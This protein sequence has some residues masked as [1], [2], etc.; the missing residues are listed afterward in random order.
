MA[1][2]GL[3]R[4]A[5]MA[6]RS[7]Y[8]QVRSTGN[9]A[10]AKLLNNARLPCSTRFFFPLLRTGKLKR[11]SESALSAKE[12][13]EVFDGFTGDWLFVNPGAKHLAGQRQVAYIAV[14]TGFTI[15][16]RPFLTN[17]KSDSYC[18]LTNRNSDR[19]AI[20]LHRNVADN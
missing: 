14:C 8:Q 15:L 12:L 20:T 9:L 18:S 11:R 13:A 3:M 4:A 17:I 16:S 7:A 10:L 2:S 6:G 5:R 19:Y 1:A